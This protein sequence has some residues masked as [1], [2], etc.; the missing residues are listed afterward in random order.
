[1]NVFCD[2][3]VLVAA[4]LQAHSHHRAAKAVLQSI[5]RG[6]D[7]GYASGHSLAE[8]FSVLSR[9]PTVPKLTPGDVLAILEQNIFPHFNLV[10]LAVVDYPDAI[11]ALAAKGVGG[12][13]I[14]DLLHLIAARKVTLDRIFTLND[15]EWKKLA[16]DLEPLI[17][18]PPSVA[19][20]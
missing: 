11:R 12:G 7:T 4:S 17:A 20:S 2:T 15:S 10:A 3:S 6:N 9:M 16:P 1:M 5:A 18:T 8:T 13:R 14:Y 19:A